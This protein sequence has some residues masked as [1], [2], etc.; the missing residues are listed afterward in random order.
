LN[1]SDAD[2]ISMSNNPNARMFITGFGSGGAGGFVDG[3]D[4]F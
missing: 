4:G 1:V 2:I 3:V